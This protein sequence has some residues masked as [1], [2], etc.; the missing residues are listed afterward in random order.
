MTRDLRTVNR[1]WLRIQQAVNC[2]LH[3]LASQASFCIAVSAINSS[4]GFTVHHLKTT[5]QDTCS[6]VQALHVA[7]Y[8]P[9]IRAC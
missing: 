4:K 2:T 3:D 1:K 8:T 9:A 5:S 6:K 7:A